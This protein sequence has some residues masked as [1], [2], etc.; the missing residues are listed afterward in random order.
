MNIPNSP[1]EDPNPEDQGALFEAYEEAVNQGDVAGTEAAALKVWEHIGEAQQD[2]EPSPWL[3]AIREAHDCEVVFDWQGAIEAYKRAI[4]G[5][6]DQPMLQSKA[7]SQLAALYGLLDQTAEASQ[8]ARA[9]TEAAR[10]SDMS[11]LIS[12]ALQAEAELLLA[13]KN[14]PVAEQKIEEA[15]SVLEA[16]AMHDLERAYALTLRGRY[17]GLVGEPESADAALDAAWKLLEPWSEMFYFAGWQ[18]GLARWWT[19]TAR[20][21]ASRG[22]QAGAVAAWKEAIERRRVVSH[23]PQLEGPYKHNAL[24]VALWE[25]GQ[26]QKTIAEPLASESLEESRSIR[27]TI[28]LPPLVERGTG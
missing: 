3:K 14:F 10:Q 13:A 20:L 1:E 21:R 7:H 22:D 24:A 25:F 27:Q 26:F 19:T 23:L 18:S 5:S 28:G 15:F 2:A 8:A 12:F 17:L 4:I 11:M 16:G 9:A 6:A